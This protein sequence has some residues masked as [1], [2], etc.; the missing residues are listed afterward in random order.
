LAIGLIDN[1]RLHL[2][3][4]PPGVTT[5]CSDALPWGQASLVPNYIDYAI[6]HENVHSMGFVPQGAPNEQS[7]GHVYDTS[8]AEPARDLMYS[9]RTSTDPAWAVTSPG[10]LILDINHDDYWGTAPALDLSRSSLLAPLPQGAVRP[11]GW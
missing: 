2:G 1:A 11:V 6:L 8:A 5:T 3:G 9:P 7:Q 4:K 10:G